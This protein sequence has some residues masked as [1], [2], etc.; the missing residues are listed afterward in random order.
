MSK[1]RQLL[2]EIHSL[3]TASGMPHC[4]PILECQMHY[5]PRKYIS[6]PL[7]R[8]NFIFS[9]FLYLLFLC[10]IFLF[11]RCTHFI[12][13]FPSFINVSRNH[14]LTRPLCILIFLGSPNPI[15]C[16]RQ[17]THERRAGQIVT[18]NLRKENFRYTLVNNEISFFS[19]THEMDQRKN[20]FDFSQAKKLFYFS[21]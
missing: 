1:S 16:T 15:V 20:F 4:Q 2:L 12:T 17:R 14:C 18:D 9:Y 3:F 7:S 13:F 5:Q 11:F 10:F 8:R 19:F 6:S 21:F